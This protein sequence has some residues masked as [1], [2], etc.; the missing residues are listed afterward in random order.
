MPRMFFY[1]RKPHLEGNKYH[2]ICCGESG[3]IHSWNIP[4]ERDNPI[5]TC[6]AEFNTSSNMKTGGLMF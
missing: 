3:T 5:A 2:T 4:E 6:R 1:N